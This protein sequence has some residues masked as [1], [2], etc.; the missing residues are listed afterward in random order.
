MAYS[1]SSYA[2]HVTPDHHDPSAHKGIDDNVDGLDGD[3][4][5]HRPV[6]ADQ[7]ARKLSARQVQMIALGGTIGRYRQDWP[8]SQTRGTKQRRS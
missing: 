7:L 4:E 1:S 2:P 6:A 3:V 8:S 5:G